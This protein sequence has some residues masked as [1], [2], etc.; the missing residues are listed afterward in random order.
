MNEALDHFARDHFFAPTSAETARELFRRSVRNVVVE[1]SSHCNRAC[2]YCPVSKVDR[3]STNKLLPHDTYEL[4]LRDLAEISYDEGLCLNLYN[5]PTSDKSLLLN[6][7]RRARE[8]LPAARIYFSS[9][10]DYLDRDYVRELISAGLSE[11]YISIHAPAGKPYDDAYA[12]TRF[13]D[14]SRRLQKAIKVD[15]LRPGETMQGH[16]TIEKLPINV[17][18][19]N[20]YT[21]GS[22]RA[23]S[24]GLSSGAFSRSAP[25]S[26]PFNDFTVSYDGTLFPCCQMFVDFAEHT[27]R[28]AIG[29]L[30]DFPT[31]FAAYASQAMAEWRKELLRYGPKLS[32][33]ATCTEGQHEGTPEQIATREKVYS[34]FLGPSQVVS[35]PSPGGSWLGG[36]RRWRVARRSK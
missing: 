36:I 2:S 9:N 20:Y 27:Q 13:N 28:Y 4:I 23:E 5:E 30:T 32:P 1:I 15:I 33:C 14:L 25:C 8:L 12:A 19:T 26:R 21:L 10:G 24:V 11:L 7:I 29:K 16:V 31:I 3:A 22:N 17:F 35:S 6:R 34:E 18:A